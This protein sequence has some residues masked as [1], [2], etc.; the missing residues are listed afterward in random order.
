MVQVGV[1]SVYTGC[2]KCLQ[3]MTHPHPESGRQIDSTFCLVP[4]ASVAPERTTP[5]PRLDTHCFALKYSH[6]SSR[7]TPVPS[8]HRTSISHFE[9]PHSSPPLPNRI[10]ARLFTPFTR[11]ASIP[12]HQPASSPFSDLILPLSSLSY[13]LR[14]RSIRFSS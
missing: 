3:V 10:F 5:A 9:Y 1:L 2:E 13:L 11:P 4:Y 8:N 7:H 12:H 14:K 6:A